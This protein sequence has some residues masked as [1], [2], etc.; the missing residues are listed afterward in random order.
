MLAPERVE[1]RRHARNRARSRPDRVV[2]ELFAEGDIE[3]DQLGRATFTTETRHR[4]EAVERAHGARPC[5]EVDRVPAAEQTG[6]HRLCDARG[7]ARGHSGVGSAT[8]CLERLDARL[9]GG[10]MP[11]GDGCA[12]HP[13]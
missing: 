12:E 4:A 3:L 7:E 2:D 11:R 6:H 13:C 9:D 8:A 5:V 10:G 1:A